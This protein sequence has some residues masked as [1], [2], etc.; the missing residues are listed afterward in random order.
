MNVMWKSLLILFCLALAG[1]KGDKSGGEPDSVMLITDSRLADGELAVG[2]E[3]CVEYVGVKTNVEDWTAVVTDAPDGWLRAVPDR[4]PPVP[5]TGAAVGQR[6]KLTVGAN[7]AAVSR[8][9]RV[10]LSGGGLERSFTVVQDASGSMLSFDTPRSAAAAGE[11]LE[12]VVTANVPYTVVISDKYPWVGDI[13]DDGTPEGTHLFRVAPN[14]ASKQRTALVEFTAAGTARLTKTLQIDQLGSGPAITVDGPSRVEVAWDA[15]ELHLRVTANISYEVAVV[16]GAGSGDWIWHSPTRAMA[17]R[18]ERFTLAANTEPEPREASVQFISTDPSVSP[19]I[20]REV[21]VVQRGCTDRPDVFEIARP[22][23][24]SFASGYGERELAIELKTTRDA[25]S[26]AVGDLPGW[27]VLQEGPRADGDVLGYTFRV[28]QNPSA[29]RRSHDIE[30]SSGADRLSVSVRQDG[31]PYSLPAV[32][33][34]AVEGLAAGGDYRTLADHD[35]GTYALSRAGASPRSWRF[36]MEHSGANRF[37]RIVYFPIA[38]DGSRRGIERY[39]IGAVHSVTGTFFSLAEGSIP[40]SFYSGRDPAAEGYEIDIPTAENVRYVVLTVGSVHGGGDVFGASG[41]E[42]YYDASQNI[43]STPSISVLTPSP[44]EVSSSAGEVFVDVEA[45]T[46]YTV[47]TSAGWIRW[48]DGYGSESGKLRFAVDANTGDERTAQVTLNSLKG[49]AASGS[50]T[51]VQSAPETVLRF[52]SPASGRLEPG[53]DGGPAEVVLTTDIPVGAITL[54]ELPEWIAFTGSE[55][56]S[57]SEVT[58]RF[59]VAANPDGARGHKITISG[60]GRMLTLDV[61]QAEAVAFAPYLR[62]ESP[63]PAQIVLGDAPVPDEFA[64]VL[65]SNVRAED[66][67]VGGMAGW[68]TG[69]GAEAA[70]GKITY[71]FAVLRNPGAARETTL[72]FSLA[73]GQSVAVTVSQSECAVKGTKVSP[74]QAFHY[75]RLLNQYPADAVCDGDMSTCHIVSPSEIRYYE[76]IFERGTS[77]AAFVYYPVD[78]DSRH[79]TLKSFTVKVG[80]HEGGAAVEPLTVTVPESVFASGAARRAGWRVD[81]PVPVGNVANIKLEPKDGHQSEYGVAEI[82]FFAPE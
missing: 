56:T 13:T 31:N 62:L 21:T 44:V 30:F 28:A 41:V 32:G 34:T 59:D 9:G 79:G 17:V 78:S 63:D 46:P 19:R 43:P 58:L 65:S 69:L 50:V 25:A 76:F 42:F 2:A 36:A 1:C 4:E 70:D 67:S 14:E 57:D 11:T 74:V 8:R 10:T 55:A 26:V 12:V 73:D 81:L 20:V 27:I 18:D 68:L 5:A 38:G 49:G 39:S 7:P 47:G 29:N 6:L 52:L 61:E 15:A 80:V 33:Y 75:D 72:T 24:G 82:E 16:A 23:G 66:I 51:V 48:D 77:L 53:S 54:G 40:A 64:V 45:N 22:V 35:T 3:A 37:N 60:G 71:R